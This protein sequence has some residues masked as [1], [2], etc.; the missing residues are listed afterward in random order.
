M[1]KELNKNALSC[2]HDILKNNQ[3][4][5]LEDNDKSTF[6]H[7]KLFSNRKDVQVVLEKECEF[8]LVFIYITAIIITYMIRPSPSEKSPSFEY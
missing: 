8:L 4:N 2:L 3:D 5:E 1:N 6:L 7:Q